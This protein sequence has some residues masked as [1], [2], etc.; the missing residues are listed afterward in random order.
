MPEITAQ[1]LIGQNRKNDGLFGEFAINDILATVIGGLVISK[2][3]GFGL[4]KSFLGLFFFIIFLKLAL[5][6]KSELVTDLISQV[7]V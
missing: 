6:V 4:I 2:I 3:Y 1:G 7:D 5:G